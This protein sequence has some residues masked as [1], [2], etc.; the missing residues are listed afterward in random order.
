MFKILS[1][2]ICWNKYIKCNNWRVAV[3]PSYIWDVRFLKVNKKCI[4]KQ[5][6]NRQTP[7]RCEVARSYRLSISIV[8][9]LSTSRICDERFKVIIAILMTL[10]ILG[11]VTPRRFVHLRFVAA[12]FRVVNIF[13]FD[14]PEY[15]RCKQYKDHDKRLSPTYSI[16]V[17]I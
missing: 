14:Y 11:D 2:Y 9:W 3:P 12:I 1:T 15:A 7:I 13:L 6:L 10:R 8:F 5:I 4:W 16:V 17:T